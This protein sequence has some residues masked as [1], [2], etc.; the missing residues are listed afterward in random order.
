VG[1]VEVPF[2][3]FGYSVHLG[4]KWL[5]ELG[6]T[7]HRLGNHFGVVLISIQGR[8][9]DCAECVTGSEII[10]GEPNVTPR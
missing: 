8:F 3:L 1:Q 2:V 6:R 10:L 4:A 9:T 7:Y 5:H